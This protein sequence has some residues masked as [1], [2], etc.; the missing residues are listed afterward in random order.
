ME[1]VLET[2]AE[3]EKINLDNVIL[4]NVVPSEDS[5]AFNERLR[6]EFG[7]VNGF[8]R[9]RVV[10]GMDERYKVFQAG[11]PRL[12][13]VAAI[14]T[15]IREVSY[16]VLQPNGQ[17]RKL[18]PNQFKQ[19]LP[20]KGEIIVPVQDKETREIGYPFWYLEFYATP[21]MLGTREQWNS[22]RWF[23]GTDLTGVYPANGRYEQLVEL[24]GQDAEGNLTVYRPLNDETFHYIQLLIKGDKPTVEE[25]RRN[26]AAEFENL[27]NDL[28]GEDLDREIYDKP[29]K[30]IYFLPESPK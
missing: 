30:P 4:H 3:T 9:F 12:R 17:V 24:S 8:P 23:D 15:V 26:K 27:Y 7:E 22:N 29:K 20:K 11:R 1:T 19:Y 13:Y 25:A 6:K 10:H 28:F 21:T 16:Q 14:Q 5:R 2:A 18:T